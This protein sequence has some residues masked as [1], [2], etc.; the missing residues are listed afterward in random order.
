MSLGSRG[1]PTPLPVTVAAAP[2]SLPARPGG[3]A[4]RENGVTVIGVD[5]FVPTRYDETSR[6]VCP[7]IPGGPFRIGD[8][9]HAQ[10]MTA[11]T[12]ILECSDGSYYVGS[13][14]DLDR[15]VSQHNRGEGAAYTRHRRPVRLVWS[16]EFDRI[17]EAFH[18]EKQVQNWGRAKRLALIEG[19][20]TDLPGLARGRNLPPADR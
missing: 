12:Y 5:V 14:T 9:G 8:P 16:V 7:Q 20:W 15:R 11:W 10:V 18:F 19:R 2:D 6:R 3:I 17:D 1:A 13:T 4:K